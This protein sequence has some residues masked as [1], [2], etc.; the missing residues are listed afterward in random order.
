V[1]QQN[2]KK[3]VKS[4]LKNV[5][6]RRYWVVIVKHRPWLRNILLGMLV[7]ILSGIGAGLY[8]IFEYTGD[9]K[10]KSGNPID[11]TRPEKPNYKK[12]SYVYPDKQ[13]SD[14]K[15]KIIGRF[16]E[17]VRDPIKIGEIPKRLQNGLIA[18]EDKRFNENRPRRLAIDYI[19]DFFY[20]GMDPCAIIRA[21]MGHL[22]RAPNT[23][24]ASTLRQQLVRHIYGDDIPEF[25]TREKTIE[26][27][28]KEA[29][30]AIQLTKRYP[31]E[32]IIQ[33]LLNLIYFGHG[34]NGIAE[35]TL[36]YFDKDIRHDELSLQE[37]AILVSL[38]KSPSLYCPIFHEPKSS[39]PKEEYEKERIKEIIRI[40]KARERYNWVLGRMLEDG[41]ISTS[42][43]EQSTFKKDEPLRLAFVKFTPLNN[44]NYG[45]GDRMIKERLFNLGY[46]DFQLSHSD[47]LRIYTTI[48]LRIQNIISEEFK[49]HLALLNEGKELK[50]RLNGSYIAIEV[51][52]GNILAI[53]GGDNFD[54][55]EY[56]R[57][58]AN[59]SVGSGFKP[60]V[61]ATAIE[62][63]GYD[64][65]DKVC[66]CAFTRKGAKKGEIWAPKN[67]KEKNPQPT[68]LIDLARGIIWSL[69]LLTLNLAK[70]T[71]MDPIVET[72][73]SMGVWG[74]AGIVR[75]SDGNIWLRRP[76]YQIKDGLVPL[77][78]T[79][80]GAS[81]VNIVELANAY[82]VFYRGGIYLRPT[83]IK[84]IR[85]TYGDQ[86]LYKPE[87]YAGKRVLSQDTSDKMLAMMRAV[88]KIGTAKISMRNIEQQVACKTGTSDGPRDVSIWCGNPDIFIAIRI[89]RDDYGVIELPEYMKK[90]S[91]DASMQVSG[92][93]VVGRLEAEIVRRI[94]S[95][96][97]PKVEFSEN[98][99]VLKQML[100]DR[101][102]S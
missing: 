101:Y 93:W 85:S 2:P 84:E 95:E 94:H 18:A 33:D 22:I 70:A 27:K 14:D 91:G 102:G 68:G 82:T 90:V 54:E 59:R 57:A 41:Y 38:N 75:D 73:N 97:R 65:F 13:Q 16:F 55:S 98:V 3:L 96:V 81:D 17:E 9:L 8:Y 44:P 12:T 100:L 92:G 46:S 35:A 77:L 67:F 72:S 7:I 39:L 1:D 20:Y 69:N 56:N 37:I 5:F 28:I 15:Q 79:A 76:G 24:G 89:G 45:Y 6:G 48:D 36:R 80:I 4:Q 51:K 58:M 11:F 87:P 10:D 63:F 40:A 25:K 74:N 47:G 78:P 43:Y 34:V 83:L 61:Y 32:K 21:G 86:M 50:D 60:L 19:C 26:R 53:S 49:E 23:S 62:K 42:E 66:N 71:T 31:K 64:L 29:R 88:T 99:E 52:T 30:I